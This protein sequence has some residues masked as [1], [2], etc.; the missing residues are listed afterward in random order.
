MIAWTT[1]KSSGGNDDGLG[2]IPAQ[3]SDGWR[4]EGG[5]REAALNNVRQL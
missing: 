3:V 5:E 1:G 4:G 2:G